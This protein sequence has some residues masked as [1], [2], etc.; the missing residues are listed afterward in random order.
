MPTDSEPSVSV[1]RRR[2]WQLPA[3]KTRTLS[4]LQLTNLVMSFLEPAAY[5]P[6]TRMGIVTIPATG[7]N[8][9][10]LNKTLGP[11]AK[12]RMPTNVL[13]VQ[14]TGAGAFETISFRETMAPNDRTS[15]FRL[16]TSRSASVCNS[17]AAPVRLVPP[18]GGVG[19]T[20][21][22]DCDSHQQLIRWLRLCAH[23]ARRG[24]LL[25]DGRRSDF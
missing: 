6:Q 25:A 3:F 12:G 20:H 11:C 16:F 4:L 10:V 2:A 9:G 18:P 22:K 5:T 19:V 21:E 13:T 24:S 7:D 17:T 8:A 15:T 23:A 14:K 1:P